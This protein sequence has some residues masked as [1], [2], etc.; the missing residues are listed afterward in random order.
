MN[1]RQIIRLVNLD[2][3]VLVPYEAKYWTIILKN[4]TIKSSLHMTWESKRI[5]Y[6]KNLNHIFYYL[7]GWWSLLKDLQGDLFFLSAFLVQIVFKNVFLAVKI[8]K[9][10]RKNLLMSCCWSHCKKKKWLGV[11]QRWHSLVSSFCFSVCVWGSFPAKIQ[12]SD[13]EKQPNLEFRDQ[14]FKKGS[15]INTVIIFHDQFMSQR[16]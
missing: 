11:K 3:T 5:L 12:L 15:K 7:N 1:V 14:F 13:T 4:L 8:E 9:L 16:P 6:F 2:L 10:C